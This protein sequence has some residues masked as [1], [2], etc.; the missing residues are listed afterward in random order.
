MAN[1]LAKLILPN[2]T[3][4][5][6]KQTLRCPDCA[7]WMVA[8]SCESAIIDKCP[9]CQGIWFDLG[10]LSVF[11]ES[12]SRFDLGKIEI[13]SRPDLDTGIILSLCPRCKTCLDEFTYSYNTKVHLKRCG[14]CSGIWSPIGQ[15]FN[16]IELS[17]ISQAIAPDLAALSKDFSD[18]RRDNQN[19]RA[20]EKTGHEL[21]RPVPWII[22]PTVILPL[23]DNI[24]RSKYPFVT[25]GILAVC[26][27]VSIFS[28]PDAALIWGMTPARI[29]KFEGL[30][31]LLSSIFVHAGIFHLMGNALYLWVFGPSVEDRI[32]HLRFAC[33]FLM[34]GIFGN[35]LMLISHSD[36][37]IPCVGASGT[38]SG[39]LGAYFCLFPSATISVATFGSILELP[40]WI[41]LGGWIG[42]QLIWASFDGGIQSAN[43]AWYAHVGGFFFGCIIT[44]VSARS[45]LIRRPNLS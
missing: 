5:R 14:K 19:W 2:L 15:T 3:L 30:F 31:T 6:K 23:H 37:A 35:F 24:E 4:L 1:E 11:R 17:K 44:L 32:G 34:A 42:L 33:L 28:A 9:D 16:L 8:Y 38:I 26:V 36:L 21:T 13:L 43:T 40:A 27:M 22:A 10:E 29:W 41:Y 25:L 12:L 39:V 18:A 20:L 45:G 7:V